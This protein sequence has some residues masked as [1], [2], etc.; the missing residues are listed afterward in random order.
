MQIDWL[1]RF[2]FYYKMWSAASGIRHDLQLALHHLRKAEAADAELFTRKSLYYYA[3]YLTQLARFQTDYGGLWILPNTTTENAIADAC[4]L[5]RKP[6]PLSELDESLL[7]STL[8]KYPELALF[9]H[10]TFAMPYLQPIVRAWRNWIRACQCARPRHPRKDCEVH[11][12]LSWITLY[13]DALD[14]Q[15]DF[16]ADWY[17]RPRPGTVVDP[18]KIAEGAF[19]LP[20]SSKLTE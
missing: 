3:E 13:M 5:I 7:R 1:A 10:A 20:P 6:V 17:Q 11:Q 8:T 14:E 2:E 9:M 18:L 16:L 19:P 12:T 15:W 4:W